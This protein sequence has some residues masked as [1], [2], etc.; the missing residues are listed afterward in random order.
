MAFQS[1]SFATDETTGNLTHVSVSSDNKPSHEKTIAASVVVSMAVLWKLVAILI[2]LLNYIEERHC[3]GF[4]Q[5]GKRCGPCWCS[6]S[7]RN[8]EVKA[9]CYSQNLTTIPAE[10]PDDVTHLDLSDNLITELPESA[11]ANLTQLTVL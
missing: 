3:S 1:F 11:F 10:I 4:P 5:A 6:R 9:D 8:P 2:A 7:E